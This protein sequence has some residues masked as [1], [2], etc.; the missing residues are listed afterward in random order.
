MYC[1]HCGAKL[2]DGAKFCASCG[3]AVSHMPAGSAASAH[4]PAGSGLRFANFMLDKIGAFIAAVVLGL[5]VVALSGMGHHHDMRQA[6]PGLGIMIGGVFY[7]VY[8]FFFET[9]WQRTPGKW[10]TGTKVVRE[11]GTKPTTGQIL[12]RTFARIIP[13]EA[14]SFFGANTI[15]W[16]D[17]FSGTLVV[18]ST[19]SADDV[20]KIDLA[21]YHRANPLAVVLAAVGAALLLAGMF[22]VLL[23]ASM[24]GHRGYDRM[25]MD[26]DGMYQNGYDQS[27][28]DNG[29]QWNMQDDNDGSGYQDDGSDNGNGQ[30]MV[31]PAVPMNPTTGTTNAQ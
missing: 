16:H 5:V 2:Q 23:F 18:P 14:F 20:K 8:Y 31:S 29:G 25:G 27:G 19:M 28:Y 17:R 22:S 9:L 15:G 6:L 4:M 13:F 24:A 26:R 10:I 7:L 30:T 21:K 3:Q 11:D 12:G 1:Q